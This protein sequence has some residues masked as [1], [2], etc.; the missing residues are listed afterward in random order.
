MK[1]N[2]NRLAM[3]ALASSLP[4]LSAAT[5]AIGVALSSSGI[6]INDAKTAGNA[7]LFDGSTVET[8]ATGS[9]LHM[10]SGA[11]VQLSAD[12][13]GK[14]FSNKIV[15]EKGVTQ[16]RGG[17]DYEVSARSLK[18]TGTDKDSSATVAL[19][20]RT[21]QVASLSGHIQVANA[22]GVIVA[23]I[24]PGMAFDFT[25]QDAGASAPQDSSSNKK[26]A[27]GAAA[28]GGAAAGISTTTAIIAGVVVVAAVGTTAGVL[29][30]QGANNTSATGTSPGRP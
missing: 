20:G 27:A 26:K 2:T 1:L 30:T 3:L 22:A 16:F 17:N 28:A 23:N 5:P 29:A 12:T 10:K 8:T 11:D 6:L 24:A 13:R 19:R 14:V 18:I 4:I 25:P 9:R 15:L 21:V 7:T